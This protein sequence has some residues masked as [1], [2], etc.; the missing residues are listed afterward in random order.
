MTLQSGANLL[1]KT[2]NV[3]SMSKEALAVESKVGHLLQEER[4]QQVA[5]SLKVLLVFLSV[6]MAQTACLTW[7]FS[8]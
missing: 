3:A 8:L 7:S 2:L 4:V 1:A 6:F 5:H